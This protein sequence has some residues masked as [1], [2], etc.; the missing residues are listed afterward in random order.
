MLLKPGCR[1]FMQSA[2][3]HFADQTSMSDF[4]ASTLT[5]LIRLTLRKTSCLVIDLT[6]YSAGRRGNLS[7]GCGMER[8]DLFKKLPDGDPYWVGSAAELEEAERKILDLMQ[9]DPNNAYLIR[10][11]ITGADRLFPALRDRP[12]AT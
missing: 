6:I 10:D 7:W 11:S 3:H 4:R 12:G 2:P 9:S 5:A 8:Y 1:G